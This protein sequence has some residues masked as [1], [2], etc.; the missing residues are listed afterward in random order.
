MGRPKI[1]PEQK[2]ARNKR[3]YHLEPEAQYIPDEATTNSQDENMY[4]GSPSREYNMRPSFGIMRL[5][6]LRQTSNV[7]EI[8]KNKR[9]RGGGRS[10]GLDTTSNGLPWRGKSNRWKQRS[11]VPVAGNSPTWNTCDHKW[12]E[13]RK[14]LAASAQTL[15]G[16]ITDQFSLGK[17]AELARRGDGIIRQ[18]NGVYP[19]L[20]AVIEREMRTM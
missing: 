16:G 5:W 13:Q 6:R 7:D 3:A 2:F 20:R 15:Y 11:R 10:G 1:L 9:R 12:R 8:P 18:M 4:D 19:A 17:V 14:Q